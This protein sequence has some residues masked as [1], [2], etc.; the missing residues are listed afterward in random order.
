MRELRQE[1][2]KGL[3]KT[4]QS[5]LPDKLKIWC[6]QFGLLPRLMWPLT[7]Y[8]INLTGTEKMER[9]ISS[10]MRECL[11]LPRCLSSIGLYG[12]GLLQLPLSSLAEEFRCTKVRLKMTLA[13]SRD[14]VI[15]A[16]APTLATGKKWMAKGAAPL[17]ISALH[18]S[19][20]MGQFQH[21]RSGMGFDE[22]CP[23]W[24][25]ASSKER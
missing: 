16:A 20:V 14:M 15:R 9:T 13:E 8:D 23:S 1:A 25:K 19:D 21:G 3:K 10:Y 24:S 6:L 7:M 4:D 11:G 12:Q 18:H 5:M 22:K 2:T 17:A